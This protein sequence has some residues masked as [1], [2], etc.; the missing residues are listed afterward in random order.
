MAHREGYIMVDHRASPGLTEDQ[1]RRAGYDPKHAGEGKMLEEAV[2]ACC[3]CPQKW[4]KNHE[5][6]RPRE[7]CPKCSNH[8]VCDVCAVEMR[9]PDYVHRPFVKLIDDVLEIAS[10]QE[11]GNLYLPLLTK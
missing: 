5:R 3:H 9:K 8:Y 4:L 10:R 1:A 2:L 11:S 7:R 6:T